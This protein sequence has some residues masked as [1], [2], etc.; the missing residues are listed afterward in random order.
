MLELPGML[1]IGAA[2]R[3]V[4]K[5]ELACSIIRSAAAQNEVTGV[6][7]TTIADEKGRCPRG[8]KGC[9]VC[10]SLKGDWC[11]TEE[12]DGPADK[13]TDTASA[14]MA[15]AFATSAPER[16]PRKQSVALRDASPDLL[17]PL[18]PSWLRA[19]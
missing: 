4:G 2:G 10:S 9:G 3:N 19:K 7:V 18:L 16:I 8:G 15:N 12:T 1:M 6:K 11:I 14:P 17:T 13:D 5:T